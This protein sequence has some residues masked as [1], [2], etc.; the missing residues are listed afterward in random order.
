VSQYLKRYNKNI[1][2]IPERKKR[3]D[4]TEEI[5]DVIVTENFPKLMILM[6]RKKSSENFKHVCRWGAGLH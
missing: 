5:L 6:Y 3:E 4:G 1:T 2:Q